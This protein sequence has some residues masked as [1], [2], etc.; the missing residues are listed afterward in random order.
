MQ[1]LQELPKVRD[2]LSYLYLE[3]G[4]V[5]QE[6]K[7]VAFVDKN[8][9]YTPI[10]AASLLALMLGPGTTITHAAVKALADNGCLIIWTGEDATR[11]YAQGIGETRKAYHLLRQAEL[12]GDEQKRLAIIRRM[13]EI[14][15]DESLDANLTLQQIRGKEGARVRTTYAQAGRRH[16]VPWKGRRYDRQS[17]S[18][19]DPINQALSTA[20]GLL[21]GMCH[22]AIVSGGYSP[23]LGFIHTGKQLS[24][25]YDIADL[26][27]AELTIPTA[28]EVVSAG[29]HD[30]R[31]RIRQACRDI[32]KEK[33][34][35]QR[36]LP[37]I[38]RLLGATELPPDAPTTLDTDPAVPTPLWDPTYED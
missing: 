20:N 2:S 8:A 1:N 12:A 38:D 18:N 17:W 14:R 34:L 21:N 16:N 27:K 24:F 32:F 37:D 30:L 36:I 13:Y 3:H 23:A 25:V 7:A 11:M 29:T 10:P 5:E 4:R 19:S 22:A 28:F 15:F 31:K 26:Y 9:S 35:L 33:R 6:Q